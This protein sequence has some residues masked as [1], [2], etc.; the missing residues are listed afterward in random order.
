MNKKGEILKQIKG[1][2]EKAS[3]AHAGQAKAIGKILSP[4]KKMIGGLLTKGIKDAYKA[5]KAAGGK[6]VADIAKQSKVSRSAAKAD[7]K[8]ELRRIGGGKRTVARVQ[9]DSLKNKA[10]TFNRMQRHKLQK[11]VRDLTQDI[12]K[13]K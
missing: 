5:Y 7:V 13:L 11:K 3:K 12:N 10:G 8:S 6:K 1:K 4:Q 2:L 9:R